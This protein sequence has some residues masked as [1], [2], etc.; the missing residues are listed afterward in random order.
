MRRRG[1]EHDAHDPECR[2]SAAEPEQQRHGREE[3][4]DDGEAGERRGD[5]ERSRH[6]SE[7]AVESVAAEP[8][9]CMLRTVRE[10]HGGNGQPGECGRRAG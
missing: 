1:A 10:H 3:L 9:E 5:A 8:S 4:G 7:R 2:E 6:P